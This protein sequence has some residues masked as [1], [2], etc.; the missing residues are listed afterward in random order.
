MLNGS[1][2]KVGDALR[3]RVERA[4]AEFGYRPDVTA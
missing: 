1:T 2:Q 3:Q 4:A